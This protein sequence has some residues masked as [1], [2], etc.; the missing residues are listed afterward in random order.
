MPISR[1]LVVDDDNLMRKTISEILKNGEFIVTEASNVTEALKYI[2]SE[3]F[4][5]LLCDLHMPGAGDGLTVVSAMRH[6]NP[7]AVTLLLSAF[8]EMDAAAKAILLQPDRIM[9]KP[10]DPTLLIE[11]VQ[12]HLDRGAQLSHP[13]E[14]VATILER[15]IPTVILAWLLRVHQDETLTVVPMGDELRSEHL[16]QI[17]IDLVLCLRS[18]KPLGAKDLSS[19]TAMMHGVTRKSQGYT[20]AMIVEESRMLQVSIFE[21]LQVNLSTIDFS[22]LLLSVMSIADEVDSQLSQAMKGYA[23]ES[24]VYLP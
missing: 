22:V 13:V 12:H 7:A 24:H 3:R 20:A 4:E 16:P 9:V 10:I 14:S 2:T 21:T 18:G 23:A 19:S 17:L 6:A 15:S 11:T 8:P 5:V 1:V